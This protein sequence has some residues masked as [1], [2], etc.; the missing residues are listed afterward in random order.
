MAQQWKEVERK[1]AEKLGGERVPVSGRTGERGMTAPDVR[2]DMWALEI[3]HRTGDIPKW[4]GKALVQAEASKHG[5]HVA[6]VAVFHLAGQRIDESLCVLRL[7][8]LA[9]IQALIEPDY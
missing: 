4:M 3:K 2:H 9:F 1:V 6:P 8:D 5:G 7:K